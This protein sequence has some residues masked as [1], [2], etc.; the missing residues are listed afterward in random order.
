M[1]LTSDNWHQSSAE[2]LLQ[3]SETYWSQ[4]GIQKDPIMAYVWLGIAA[5]LGSKEAKKRRKLLSVTMSLHDITK[6]Q[7]IARD[8]LDQKDLLH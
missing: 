8:M 7:S 2:L 5:R 4:H 6:A 1:Q 3:T